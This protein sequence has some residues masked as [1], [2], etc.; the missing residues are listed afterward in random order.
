MQ[1][2]RIPG[3]GFAWSYRCRPITQRP[4]FSKKM[5]RGSQAR[6]S[7][8]HRKEEERKR[9]TRGQSSA[10][11][12]FAEAT[13]TTR[14]LIHQLRQVESMEEVLYPCRRSLGGTLLRP[15]SVEQM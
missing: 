12:M 1:T 15:P 3:L 11:P 5:G 9:K 7:S 13:T 14:W 6:S 10:G 4:M 8:Q 2:R